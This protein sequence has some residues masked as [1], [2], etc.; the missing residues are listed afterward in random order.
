MDDRWSSTRVGL[1]PPARSARGNPPGGRDPT[2]RFALRANRSLRSRKARYAY[3]VKLDA[4]AD[5]AL[6][7]A[8]EAARRRWRGEVRAEHVM[9]ALFASVA[10]WKGLV[11][12]AI[13]V[14]EFK[15]RVEEAVGAIDEVGGYRGASLDPPL[16]A[17]VKEALELAAALRSIPLL[18]RVR[19]E[20]LFYAVLGTP[21]VARLVLALRS[22][23]ESVE[24]VVTRARALAAMY[25][26]P[27]LTTAHVLRVLV[28]TVTFADAV[29][30]AGG[31]LGAIRAG[32]DGVLSYRARRTRPSTT[33]EALEVVLESARRIERGRRGTTKPRDILAIRLLQDKT[34]VALLAGWSVD[35]YDVIHIMTHGAPPL[36]IA[37]IADSDRVEVVFHDD[38]FTPQA[39]VTE[40]LVDAFDVPEP[41]AYQIMLRVDNEGLA[42]AGDWPAHEARDRRD[43][44]IAR[45]RSVGAPLRITLH[46]LKRPVA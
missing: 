31:E 43:R 32:L 9:A 13:D 20:H 1:R 12:L 26:H 39:I 36:E 45:A 2:A 21:S 37:P 8:R 6:A 34:A 44:A 23:D 25:G 4:E 38:D 30:R 42:I 17:E 15:G 41:E 10:V 35:A 22:S 3:I 24:A 46:A 28:D 16:S 27:E 29:A 5:A 11:E 19:I 14:K 7:R 33:S 18:G 40:I